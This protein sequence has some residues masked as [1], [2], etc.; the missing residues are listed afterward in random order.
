MDKKEIG[1]IILLVLLTSIGVNVGSDYVSGERDYLTQ[2]EFDG[3]Y[4]CNVN[5]AL[6][7]FYDRLSGTSYTAYPNIDDGK[8]RV[9]CKAE[10]GTKGVWQP[11]AEYADANGLNPLELLMKSPVIEPIP[12]PIGGISGNQYSCMAP[13]DRGCVVK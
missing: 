4:I 5:L 10:D 13:A 6:S 3:A 12:A 7:G 9:Y 1:S 2:A 8:G 11:L